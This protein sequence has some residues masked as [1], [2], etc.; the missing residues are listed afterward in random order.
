MQLSVNW[1]STLRAKGPSLTESSGIMCGRILSKLDWQTY[2]IGYFK[3]GKWEG[4]RAMS[5]LQA[6]GEPLTHSWCDFLSSQLF[7]P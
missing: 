6:Q 2:K 7:G 4:Q 5:Q 3:V 1:Q